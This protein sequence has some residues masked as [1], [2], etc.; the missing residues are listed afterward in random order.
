[1][2]RRRRKRLG[3]SRQN[4]WSK[5]YPQRYRLKNGISKAKEDPAGGRLR[6]NR[7]E[8][9]GFAERQRAVGQP[10][11][12]FLMI[13]GKAVT[14][15][16]L[17]FPGSVSGRSSMQCCRAL[18]P[19]QRKSYLPADDGRIVR[20][21]EDGTFRG[22]SQRL[23][24]LADRV[25]LFPLNNCCWS[26]RCTPTTWHLP[27]L[28]MKRPFTPGQKRGR[29]GALMGFSVSMALC[30]GPAHLRFCPECYAEEIRQYGG[31]LAP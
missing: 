2:L 23:N 10:G 17:L 13:F 6:E 5:R 31:V 29:L 21:E 30:G 11:R 26:I 28:K 25:P 9:A 3:K 16:D 12:R 22:T 4:Q 8:D 7:S 15:D 27:L 14:Q 19:L 20:S 24:V 1:M 18:P